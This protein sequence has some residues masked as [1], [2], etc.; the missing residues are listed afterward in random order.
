MNR[1]KKRNILIAVSFLMM[2]LFAFTY[3]YLSRINIYQNI[4]IEVYQ[5]DS[6]VTENFTCKGYSVFNRELQINNSKLIFRVPIKTYSDRI[7]ILAKSPSDT[8]PYNLILSCDNTELLDTLFYQQITIDSIPKNHN[9]IEKLK[10]V[11]LSNSKPI[12]ILL[13]CIPYFFLCVFLFIKFFKRKSQISTQSLGHIDIFIIIL[14]SILFICTT[15]WFYFYFISNTFSLWGGLFLQITIFCVLLLI[16]HFLLKNNHEKRKNI[17]TSAT[18][19]IVTLLIAEVVLRLIGYDTTYFNRNEKPLQKFFYGKNF[20]KCYHTYTENS[21][22]YLKTKEFSYK[23]K[24]NSLGLSDEELVIDSTKQLIIALGDSFTEG[25]G[26]HSDSTWLKFLER[27]YNSKENNNYKFFN[28]GICGSDPFYEYRLLKDKLVEYEPKIVIVCYGYDLSDVILRGGIERF[29]SNNIALKK[30]WWEGIYK[31]SFIFRLAISNRLGDNDLLLTENEYVIE[32]KRALSQLKGSLD[33]FY[34]LSKDANFDLVVV[35]YPLK[36]ELRN[37][38]F[39]SN[40]ILIDY[41]KEKNI[42]VLDLLDY[43]SN[44]LSITGDQANQYYWKE[45]GHNNSK[46]YEIFAKGVYEKLIELGY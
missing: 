8:T 41:C 29:D 18:S 45:D 9:R 32:K 42:N 44:T 5:D 25:D 24:T 30:K 13:I 16:I 36:N 39:D 11:L 17:L 6:N 26:T 46:G 20:I 4:N 21:D 33:M 14:L 19:V 15:I 31:N 3:L 37:G 7:E 43:Y 35:F 27:D 10:L 38:E 2:G 1:Q 22:H 34:N 23:R 28:A 40:N 12:G